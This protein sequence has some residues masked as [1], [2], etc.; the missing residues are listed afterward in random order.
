MHAPHFIPIQER[1][2]GLTRETS[3]KGVNMAEIN[4]LPPEI[5]EM[6][7]GASAPGGGVKTVNDLKLE[8][9]EKRLADLEKVNN[10]LR[11]A[12]AE[13]YAFAQAQT[14]PVQPQPPV[15]TVTVGS[16]G[17]TLPPQ[18]VTITT[19]ASA[20]PLPPDQSQIEAQRKREEQNLQAV[21]KELGGVKPQQTVQP[22]EKDG[23]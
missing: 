2:T 5:V 12:N 21:L 23:M 9:F 11:Q 16:P 18:S 8:Q 6:I 22:N 17:T 7:K 13:L 3:R 4:T 1:D 19:L 10:E 20:Q 15:Q 14:Q